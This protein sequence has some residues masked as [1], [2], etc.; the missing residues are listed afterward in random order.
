M[1]SR[2]H[3]SFRETGEEKNHGIK[4]DASF[5]QSKLIAKEVH[6][7]A[8]YGIYIYIFSF[9]FIPLY[10]N[11]IIDFFVLCCFFFYFKNIDIQCENYKLNLF[12][13]ELQFFMDSFFRMCVCVSG[14]NLA[15]NESSFL[16]LRW[17]I[18]REITFL[19]LSIP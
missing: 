16:L 8:S 6:R 5:E 19:I 17:S 4:L 10:G 7:P 11:Y 18:V 13:I 1:Q 12:F 3:C 15:R 14:S 2:N 9:A